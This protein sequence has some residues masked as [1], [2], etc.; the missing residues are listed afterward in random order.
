MSAPAQVTE[1]QYQLAHQIR[2]SS[3]QERAAQLIADSEAKATAELRGALVLGQ[4]NCDD[5]YDDLR[6]ERKDAIARAERAEA[7]V[8]DLKANNRFHRG[9]SAGYAEAKADCQSEL[10]AERARLDWLMA[11]GVVLSGYYLSRLHYPVSRAAIDAA[12]K[13]PQ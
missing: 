12:M 6:A 8:A 2:Q 7:E 5:A 3:T 4:Q 9:H 11:G 13:D 1:A 10:A